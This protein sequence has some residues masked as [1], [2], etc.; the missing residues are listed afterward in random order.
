M[1]KKLKNIINGSMCLL[2]MPIGTVPYLEIDD[3]SD[4]DRIKGDWEKVGMDIH[5][6]MQSF[7]EPFLKKEP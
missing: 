7:D 5:N 2:I 6:A 3:K 1:N 4:S